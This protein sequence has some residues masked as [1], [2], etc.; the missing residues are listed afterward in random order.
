MVVL[1]NL[2]LRQKLKWIEFCV[3]GRRRAMPQEIGLIM[4]ILLS[5]KPRRTELRCQ[6]HQSKVKCVA[7]TTLICTLYIIYIIFYCFIHKY[8]YICH[9]D[10]KFGWNTRQVQ[11]RIHR[12]V[13]AVYYIRT[14]SPSKRATQFVQHS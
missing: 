3:E 12:T 7:S 2:M 4:T 11:N 8:I 14:I 1:A 6:R 9:F 5:T 10:L 13:F